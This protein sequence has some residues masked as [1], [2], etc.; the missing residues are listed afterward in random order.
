MS[1]GDTLLIIAA[2]S[3][4]AAIITGGMGLR[5]DDER[6]G[7]ASRYASLSA[8]V[9]ITAVLLL[10]IY[11]FLSSDLSYHYVWSHSS[12]G[13]DP[14]YKLVG[15]W[16]GGEGGLVL[17][18]WFMAMF[19]AAE[20]ILEKRRHVSARFSAAFRMAASSIVLL[21]S[22]IL[23]AAGLFEGTS[24]AD[25]LLHPSGLGM[26]ISLQTIEMAIHPP[27][28][29]AAYAACLVIFSASL[30]RYVSG[31]ENWNAIAL[32]WARIAGTLLLAGIAVGAV[33][34]YYELGWGGF[35]VWDPVETASLM[36]FVAVIAFL[37]ARR[38]PGA[39]D[40]ALMPFLGMLTFVLVLLSSFITRTGGLWG[41]SVHTYGSTLT[42]PIGT[43]LVTVLTGDMSMM[44]L[45]TVI[46][47]LFALSLIFAY[48]SMTKVGEEGKVDS[49]VLLT[50]FLLLVYIALLLLL[51][52]KNT[53]LDQGDNFVE[54]TEKTSLL[55]FV[56]AVPLLFGL[57][58]GRMGARRS[59]IASGTVAAAAVILAIVAAVTG[60]VP[61]LVALTMPPALAVML[62]SAYRIS[63]IDQRKATIWLGRAGGHAVHLGIAL[64]LLSFIVSSTMQASLPEGSASM[65][66]G[67]SIKI[68]DH[69]V[70]LE[71]LSVHQWTTPTGEPGEERV[72]TFLVYSGG[73]PKTV[74]ISN[75][76]QNDTSGTTLLR[77]G[78]AV[79]NGL[80]EDVYLNF[81]WVDN[82]TALVQARVVP[83][84]T[85]V[86]LGFGIATLGMAAT[87][88]GGGISR[89]A[90]RRDP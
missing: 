66:I 90:N 76:Y 57:L 63:V 47:I 6:L 20:V 13:L 84:V 56:M 88:L 33:W 30:G 7:R 41:S 77:S 58:S 42:G 59:A 48:R 34:A 89:T 78:T 74:T 45:F 71:D 9:L 62:A 12:Q 55:S 69:T 28:V 64:V 86:W 22:L 61:W 25:L 36:P 23:L 54:F 10:L 43:R 40:G 60:A 16:A 15:V 46:I 65:S 5:R 53:G 32:P 80:A 51:L 79:V 24:P 38:S 52:I 44:G 18:T 85:E 17:W 21:F 70:H 27:L 2:L 83:M 75:L 67:E 19:L 14:F 26:N 81:A 37:H 8:F 87:L 31:E 73:S 1:I 39:R 3:S 68:G 11:L 35:W 72:A 50:V 4:L 29:F 82:D 49:P